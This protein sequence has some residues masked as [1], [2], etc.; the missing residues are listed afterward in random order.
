[1]RTVSPGVYENFGATLRRG[2]EANATWRP[3]EQ[4]E[5]S[6]VYGLSDT[7]VEKNADAR[8]L[9]LPIAGVPEDSGSLEAT[10]Q[11]V[12]RLEHRA[13]RGATSAKYEV[14]ALNTFEASSYDLLDLGVAYT[15]RR[16][17]QLSRLCARRQRDR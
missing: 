3:I 4:F 12:R 16:R 7:E 2:V 17:A 15:Q 11:A 6:A 5:L 1:M 8:L 10:F 14:D 13:L 9:G